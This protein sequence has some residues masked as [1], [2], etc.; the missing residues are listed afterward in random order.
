MSL[1]HRV[2]RDTVA[3][4]EISR[5]GWMAL[6]LTP[7]MG[8]IRARKAVERL[9]EAARVFEASLTELEGAGMPASSAQFVFEGRAAEEAEAEVKRLTEAGGSFL[10][11]ED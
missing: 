8:A 3:R 4:R 7:G 6:I 1:E 5:L 9:G 10:T 2:E 11:P